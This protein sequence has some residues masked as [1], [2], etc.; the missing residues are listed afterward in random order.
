M[1]IGED[2]LAP[3]G[4]GPLSCR[5]GR[6]D[7]F[8]ANVARGAERGIIERRQIVPDRAYG[9]FRD[10]PAIP[11]FARK[12]PLL[13]GI[14]CDQAGIAGKAFSADKPFIDASLDGRLEQMAQDIA[15]AEAAVA[16]T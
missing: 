5:I 11:I 8:G 14:R 2:G 12:R 16:I 3:I 6:G 10:G 15:L 9:V 7:E 4:A 13:V 1:G